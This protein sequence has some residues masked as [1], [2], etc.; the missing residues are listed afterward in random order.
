[1][2]SPGPALRPS[3]RSERLRARPAPLAG[4]LVALLLLLAGCSAPAGTAAEED[5]AAGVRLADAT[6][7]ADPKNYV[8]ASTAVLSASSVEPV[9]ESPEPDLPVTVTD[10]QGTEVTVDDASRVLAL[11]LSGS[12]SQIVFQLGLGDRMVGRDV[13]ADFPGS[14][15]LPLV[16][17]GGHTLNAEAI[18]DL[19]PTVL[20]TDTTLGPWDAVLQ[21]RDAGI[22]VVVVD[23]HRDL[24]N[25]A[26]L[27]HQVAGALG[28]PGP[29]QQLADSVTAAVDAKV[30]EIAAVAPADPAAR[31]RIVFLY[32]RGQAGVFYMFGEDSGAD[33]LVTAVGGIDVATEVGWQGMKP[34]NAE[35]LIAAQPDL[36]L[37]MTE[38]LRSVGGVEGLLENIPGLAQTPAG[39]RARVVDMADSHLL[40]FGPRT[41]D[42]LDALATAIYAPGSTAPQGTGG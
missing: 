24:E 14:D 33:S 10:V 5:V 3:L 15:E 11:D 7:I 29:G 25:I 39:Q 41:A 20:I 40:S 42:V 8:G 2:H 12:L 35:G 30:A 21:V 19:A 31:L 28:V 17:E 16:T 34:V 18:L 1:M 38:G 27:I 22:P 36:V 13:S 32:V 6:L 37:V 23:P 9:V 4:P 26:P